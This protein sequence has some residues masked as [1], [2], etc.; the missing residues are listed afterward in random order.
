MGSASKSE[1]FKVIEEQIKDNNVVTFK[2]LSRKLEIHNSVA[3]ELLQEYLD[4]SEDKSKYIVT[5]VVYGKKEQ[6]DLL[7][8]LIKENEFPAF[9]NT[10]SIIDKHVYSIQPAESTFDPEMIY[11]IDKATY[12]LKQLSLSSIK[13]NKE[14]IRKST[15]VQ[16][17]PVAKPET[18][19]IST[20]KSTPAVKEKLEVKKESPKQQS[21]KKESPPSKPNKE[22]KSKPETKKSIVKPVANSKGSI[23]SFFQ[24]QAANKTNST[25]KSDSSTKQE[26]PVLNDSSSKNNDSS[27]QEKTEKQAPETKNK[28]DEPVSKT[29]KDKSPKTNGVSKT[30]ETE[31]LAK[32]IEQKA[33]SSKKTQNKSKPKKSNSKKGP[34]QKKMKRIILQSDSSSDGE[35][36]DND[37]HM[38]EPEPEEE[39]EPVIL[40]PVKEPPAV[41]VS[42]GKKRKRKVIDKTVLDEEGYMRTTKEVVYESCSS[43]ENDEGGTNNENIDTNKRLKTEEKPAEVKTKTSNEE[44]AKTQSQKTKQASIMNFFK[45]PSKT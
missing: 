25:P 42:H 20:A 23:S 39:P 38:S 17:T 28:K 2:W 10:I 31:S 11:N 9:Q 1:C 4:E 45:K 44:V 34:K 40:S 33:N 14:I 35:G 29:S 27:D 16:S 15:T 18:S 41:I 26:S 7:L 21:P 3:K 6:G 32:K 5:L 19:S 36:S 8:S 43:D 13:Y 30:M 22:V 12:E 37:A 24:K